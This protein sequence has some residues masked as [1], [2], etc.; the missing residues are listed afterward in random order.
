M[1]QKIGRFQTGNQFFEWG[2]SRIGPLL[3]LIYVNDLD[4]NL[5]SNILKFADGTKVFRKVNYDGD[6]QHLQNNLDKSVK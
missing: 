6:K 3:F 5:I 2:T 4:S 1:L